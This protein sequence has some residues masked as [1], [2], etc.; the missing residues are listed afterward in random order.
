MILTNDEGSAAIWV[1]ALWPILVFFGG[2]LWYLGRYKGLSD[3]VRE[4]LAELRNEQRL[5]EQSVHA[6]NDRLDRLDLRLTATETSVTNHGRT[7]DRI[8][9]KL[10][11]LIELRAKASN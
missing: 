5:A 7:L 2:A 10:D 9:A 3:L 4:R 11:R 6:A 1:E 8:E